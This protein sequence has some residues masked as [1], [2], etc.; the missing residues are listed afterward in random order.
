MTSRLANNFTDLEVYQRAKKLASAL[1]ERTRS[2]PREEAY[3]LTDQLR[4]SSRAIGAQIAEAW[5]K[6]LYPGYF[7]SKLTDADAQ[8]LETQHWIAVAVDCRHLDREEAADR[9][10]EL[11]IIG[12]MLGSMMEKARLF[13]R[14]TGPHANA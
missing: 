13:C 12:R 3:S 7:L 6:R 4:H 1:F 2:F 5:G 9:L 8:Q 10:E 11:A 14:E